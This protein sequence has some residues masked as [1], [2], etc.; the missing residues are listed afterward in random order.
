MLNVVELAAAK[1]LISEKFEN[2]PTI[3][4]DLDQATDKVLAEDLF[5]PQNLPQFNRSMMDGYAVKS[6]QTN[7]AS[8]SVPVNFKLIGEVKM[9]QVTSLELQDGTCA[10]VPTGAM[11][12]KRSDSV[13]M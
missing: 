6:W 3:L 13:V 5:C 1:K 12:P 10:Y 2:F 8:Q 7:G 4:L 9:G 11:L